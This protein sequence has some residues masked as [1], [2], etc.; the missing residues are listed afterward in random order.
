MPL[1]TATFSTGGSVVIND[2][3]EVA[4]IE[5]LTA[6]ITAQNTLLTANLTPA[7]I[8][9]P[10]TPVAIWSAQQDALQMM[11]EMLEELNDRMAEMSI[12]QTNIEKRMEDQTKG[13]ATMVHLA[14]EQTTT[15]QMAYLDQVKNNQFQQQ[16]TNAALAEVGKPPTVVT[17]QSILAK[18]QANVQDITVLK[19]EQAA[20]NA[21]FT[22]I[23][24]AITAAYTTAEAWYLSSAIGTFITKAWGDLK[25][26]VKSLFGIQEAKKVTNKARRTLNSTKA[27]NPETL[28]T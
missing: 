10:G 6:A 18:I 23:S 28:S 2:T 26:K 11:Q 20:T 17:P 14:A 24:E 22:K 15:A 8:A 27:G 13:M 3:V 4:A 25:A 5:A 21:V 12:Q 16:T 9:T 1:V 19:A 7:G